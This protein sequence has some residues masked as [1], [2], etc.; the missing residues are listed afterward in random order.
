MGGGDRKGGGRE[1]VW[2]RRRRKEEEVRGREKD[3]LWGEGREA[4]PPHSTLATR[5]PKVIR[6]TPRQCICGSM[7]PNTLT[8]ISIIVSSETKESIGFLNA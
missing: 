4:A 8:S 6:G 7:E 2:V 5:T 3:S 1:I